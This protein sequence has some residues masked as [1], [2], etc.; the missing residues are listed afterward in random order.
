MSQKTPDDKLLDEGIDLFNEGH[1]WEAHEAWE[2]IWLDSEEPQR[3]FIQGLIQLTAAFHHFRRGTLRGGIRLS[4]AAEEKLSSYPQDHL[5]I[6][7]SMAVAAS[8]EARAWAS[9]AIREGRTPLLPSSRF[10]RLER[11]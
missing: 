2:R 10:P 1:F 8:A 5:R 7:R 3:T 9:E 11:R 6:D 4:A